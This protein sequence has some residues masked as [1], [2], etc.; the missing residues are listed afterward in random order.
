M[1]KNQQARG[2]DFAKFV[3]LGG[4]PFNV[5]R[6]GRI[7]GAMPVDALAWTETIAG[8]LRECAADARKISKSRKVELRITGTATPRARRE[9]QAL[10]WRLQEN[11]KF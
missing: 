9:L 10:G 11:A 1:L 7:V 5:T 4:Y 6:D 3:L 8:V 2:A